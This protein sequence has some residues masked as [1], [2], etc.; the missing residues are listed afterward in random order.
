MV[1]NA[2]KTNA[3][4]VC[5]Q[6]DCDVR[7]QEEN[8]RLREELETLKSDNAQIIKNTFTMGEINKMFKQVAQAIWE[9]KLAT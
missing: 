6:V 2:N 1:L 5:A 7:L 9:S 3:E 4:R 8:K